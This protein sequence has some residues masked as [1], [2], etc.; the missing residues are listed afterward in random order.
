MN[1]LHQ[2]NL[3]KLPEL[4]LNGKDKSGVKLLATGM[5]SRVLIN[6]VKT[7]TSGREEPEMINPC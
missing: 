5:L 1:A 7:G 6:S 3:L 2:K 4:S